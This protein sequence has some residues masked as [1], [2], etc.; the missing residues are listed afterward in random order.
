MTL[1]KN[2]LTELETK[3]LAE[4][5]RIEEELGRI[6]K[7]SDKSGSY[8]TEFD[9]I[10]THEDENASEVEEYTDNLALENTLEKQLKDIDEALEKISLGTYG[11]CENCKQEID[12]ERLKAYPAAKNCIKCN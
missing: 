1:E 7:P 8:E 4:K 6:A 2:E 12:I 11:F 9:N 10:G 3:L 5:K